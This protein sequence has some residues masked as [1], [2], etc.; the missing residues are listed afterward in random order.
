MGDHVLYTLF[1]FA[2]VLCFPTHVVLFSYFDFLRL[3]YPMF[4]VSLDCPPFFI[5]PSVFSNVY[6]EISFH[7]HQYNYDIQKNIDE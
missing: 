6:L 2:N 4:P 3:V 1:V 7:I 5:V